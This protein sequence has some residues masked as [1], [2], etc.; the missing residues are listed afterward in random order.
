M[1]LDAIHQENVLTHMPFLT[2]LAASSDA[3]AIVDQGKLVLFYCRSGPKD[4]DVSAGSRR[5]KLWIAVGDRPPR[6]LET[7]LPDDLTECSPTAW[8]DDTGWHVTFIAGGASESPLYRLYRMDGPD[9]DDLSKPV[10]IHATRAAFVYGDRLVHAD[11]ENLIYVRQPSGDF[12]IELP[13][14]FIYRVSYR[15]DEPDTLL[16]SG[17]WQTERDVFALEYDLRTGEQHLLECDG[18]PAYKCT[19]LGNK[20]LYAQR[21]GEHF[22]HRR[23]NTSEALSRRRVNT[24]V[25]RQPGQVQPVVTQ[26]TGGCGCR[27]RS[28]TDATPLSASSE[29]PKAEASSAINS[30]ADTAPVTRASCL[31]CIEKHLGAALVLLTETREGYAHRLRA[32]GHLHEAEDESQ[33]FPTLHAAI[34]EARKAYQTAGTMPDWETLSQLARE[35]QREDGGHRE[36]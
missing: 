30:A 9:L 24:I 20:V 28:Q 8:S 4:V 35:P 10:A 1:R 26:P 16:I 2:R 14:A 15:A 18:L 5:W 32:I 21:I 27:G 3:E 6:R 25:R 36:R 33:E 7:G 17:A 11:P 29:P 23:I 19:I 31:E 13:G 12:D 34:R 22:E